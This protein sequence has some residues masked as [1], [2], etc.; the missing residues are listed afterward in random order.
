[1]YNLGNLYG[2]LGRHHEA[3][4]LEEKALEFRKRI[5]PENHPA[6]GDALSHVVNSASACPRSLCRNYSNGTAIWY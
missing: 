3:L 5:F 6:I 2:K 1:M 4:E